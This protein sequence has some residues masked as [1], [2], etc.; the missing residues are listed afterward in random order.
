MT[1]SRVTL[2]EL[3]ANDAQDFWELR[4]QG[5]QE[6]VEAFTSSYEE[7]KQRPLSTVA[8][9]LHATE[10]SFVLGAFVD[11][12][13]VGMAGFRRDNDSY[14]VR[15]KGLIWGVYVKPQHRGIGLAKKLLLAAIE[16]S[17]SL[18]GI[19]LVHLGVNAAN[20]PVKKLYESVGFRTW[21]CEPRALK[22]ADRYVDEER[23]MLIV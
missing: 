10:N 15:H 12:K 3:R 11:D 18:G 5:L 6:E 13:L 7:S 16:K 8:E 9:S 1:Q 19:E 20:L 21:G 2:R 23:M 4:L 17:R 14:K 22:I